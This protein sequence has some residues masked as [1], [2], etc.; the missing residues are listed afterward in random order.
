MACDCK[1]NGIC[2]TSVYEPIRGK[3]ENPFDF[4]GEYNPARQYRAGAVVAYDDFLWVATAY[5]PAGEE[6]VGY[7]ANGENGSEALWFPIGVRYECWKM[8]KAK[9]YSK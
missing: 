9:V 2:E 7:M 3:G 6:P 1:T 5:V 8:L 4:V